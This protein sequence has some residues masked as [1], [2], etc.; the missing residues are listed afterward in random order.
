MT[1]CQ[2]CSDAATGACER[3]KNDVCVAH[4]PDG[5]LCSEC[6]E[7]WMEKGDK[8]SPWL[9]IGLMVCAM[10]LIVVTPMIVPFALI[11]LGMLGAI[12]SKE[13]LAKRR[14]QFMQTPPAAGR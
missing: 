13:G 5:S 10:P 6:L 7:E 12:L 11:G 3:C 2:N 4:Q 1:T 14:R 8:T 9:A